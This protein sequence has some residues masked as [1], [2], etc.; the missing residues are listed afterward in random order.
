[1]PMKI[2][3]VRVY[4]LDESIEAS[5]YP[6]QT[7][8][9]DKM[10]SPTE[11]D[12]KRAKRLGNAPAGSGHDCFLKGI[13][14]QMDVT[15]S[16]KWWQQ[17]QRY[18]WFDIVSSCS[19]MHKAVEFYMPKMCHPLVDD[20]IVLIIQE[21]Q[22]AYK[23]LPTTE[24][25]LRLIYSIPVGLRVTAR[26]TTNYLQLKTMYAQRRTHRLPEWDEFCAWVD[27]LPFSEELGVCGD[28]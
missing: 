20:R 28:V 1:M 12:T 10:Q 4:G 21:L 27:I 25:F 16:I 6:M 22:K 7:W 13:V 14:V 23:T 3:N 17:A 19:T 24:N 9:S 2:E 18:N 15:A 11:R 26:V 8:V 5:G